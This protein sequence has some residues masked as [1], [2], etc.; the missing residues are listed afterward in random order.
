MLISR[1]LA[2]APANGANSAPFFRRPKAEIAQIG[3]GGIVLD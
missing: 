1:R 2:R 3:L